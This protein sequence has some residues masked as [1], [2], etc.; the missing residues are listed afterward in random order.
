[1]FVLDNTGNDVNEFKLTTGFDVSTASYI[2]TFS[3]NDQE[4]DPTGFAFTFSSL[5]K[6]S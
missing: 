3:V 4:D 5:H 1:M 2:Q 6:Y